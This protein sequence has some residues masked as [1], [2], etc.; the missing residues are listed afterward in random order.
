[1]VVMAMV[2]LLGFTALALDGSMAYSDRRRAQSAADASS[3]AGGNVAGRALENA[4]IRYGNWATDAPSC[5]G[6]VG[7]AARA[8]REAAIRRAKDNEFTLDDDISDQMGVKTICDVEP[9]YANGK[10]G[11]PVKIFDDKYL[12]VVSDITDET[13]TA[14]A[15]LVFKGV[16][17]NTV[18]AVTRVRPR[19]P[20]AYGFS[21]VALNPAGCLGNQNGVQYRG[22]NQLS[23]SGGGVWSNGCMEMDG[24]PEVTV[25][26]G[27]MIYFDPGTN[28]TLDKIT[29][30]PEGE[31][32]QLVDP[33]DRIPQE[34]YNIPAPDCAGHRMSAADFTSYW[35]DY[36][37]PIPPGLWCI[38]GD[39]NL[40]SPLEH[41]EGHGV[42][43]VIS[44]KLSITGGTVRLWA[45]APDYVG[46]A[47]PG[48]LFYAPES[49]TNTWK[50]TGNSASYMQ[51][52]ILAPG[53]T[54]DIVGDSLQNPFK[55]QLIAW[56]VNIGGTSDTALMFQDDQQ[57]TRP[58]AMDM[59]R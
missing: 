50:I 41:V 47:I 35:K 37:Q 49:N 11:T 1:M 21:I 18:T 24:N 12:D 6:V 22:D 53:A 23:I 38:S 8:G 44:G 2:V 36:G 17:K 43:L 39:I 32:A 56:N 54:V 13:Q 33:S 9:I 10:N 34:A 59:Y 20:L 29:F 16:V 25:T 58:T 48:V 40:N 45:P 5:T 7:N 46:P 4:G 15:H 42:T 52:T 28:N 51:G 14:F 55:V 19:Q 27:S 26:D 57:Y 3:L 31:P 30:E